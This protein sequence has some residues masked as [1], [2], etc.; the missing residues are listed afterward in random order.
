MILLSFVSA[1]EQATEEPSLGF[2]GAGSGQQSDNSGL[3]LTPFLVRLIEATAEI[4]DRAVPIAQ[5]FQ[6]SIKTSLQHIGIRPV[7]GV[8]IAVA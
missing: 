6:G 7:T 1:A 4:I 8:S 2:R 5:L 3:S